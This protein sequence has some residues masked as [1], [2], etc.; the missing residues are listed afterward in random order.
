MATVAGVEALKR[1]SAL[2][3]MLTKVLA[4]EVAVLLDVVVAD[5]VE[6]ADV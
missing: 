6:V 3:E 1:A 5:G 4:L 2:A